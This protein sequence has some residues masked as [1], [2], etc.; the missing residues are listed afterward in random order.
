MKTK[1]KRA[2]KARK[3]PVLRN[4]KQVKLI[5]GK[6]VGVRHFRLIEHKHTFKLIHH[7][8]TSHLGLFMILIL[9]GFFMYASDMMVRADSS[10]SVIIGTIVPGPPPTI[11][12]TIT[13]PTNGTTIK[14]NRIIEVSGTC[15]DNSFV[16]VKNSGSIV[17][18]TACTNGGF[19]LQVQLRLGANVL[20]AL[21]YDNLNQVGPTT[22]SV[23]VYITE[24]T[25]TPT[26]DPT[27][28]PTPTPAPAP[29]DTPR[30]EQINPV[31]PDNPSIIT[32]VNS[33]FLSCNDYKPGKLPTGGELRVAV[34][35][36]PRLFMPKVQQVMGVLVWGGTPPYALHVNYG[37]EGSENEESSLL[38]LA[39]PGYAKVNFSYAVPNTYRIKF[40]LTDKKNSAA[41][42]ETAVQVNGEQKTVAPTTIVNEVTKA[43]LGKESWFESPVPFYLLAVAITIGFWCGDLFDRK[44]GS[45]KK[46]TR[47]RAAC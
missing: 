40:R 4:K 27:P 25:P 23:T 14:D 10:G 33:S 36:V 15:Y 6:H 38:S 2:G 42:V 12:A 18:S 20:T 32:G 47:K 37:T 39:T 43:I 28:E 16:I 46:K 24:S 7:R 8:H 35:C 41:V 19:N 44:F 17:G 26:P 13:N 9:V 34:V 31:L 3:Q 5:S 11:G 1:P 21:N 22:P 29:V 30:V 45:R